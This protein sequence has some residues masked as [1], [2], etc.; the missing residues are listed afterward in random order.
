MLTVVHRAPANLD[1]SKKVLRGQAARLSWAWDGLCFAVPM[2][3]SNN[4]GL[5]DVVTNL[6][7]TVATGPPSWAR[8]DRGNPALGFPPTGYLGWADNPVHD[9]PS[10]A[11]TAYIRVRNNAGTRIEGGILYNPWSAGPPWSTW[12]IQSGPTDSST[13]YGSLSVGT[14]IEYITDFTGSITT[15]QWFSAFLRWRSGEALTMDVLDERGWLLYSVSSSSAVIGALGYNPGR[16]I[17][18]NSTAADSNY[19]GTYSQALVWNRRLTD[20]EL[21]ALVSDPYGWYSPRRET[22]GTSSP[23]PLIAGAGEM[24]SGGGGGGIY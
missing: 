15:T 17:L 11:L 9:R 14:D 4:E 24:K 16:G 8:D 3:E 21:T 7:P 20:T 5:R 6:M 19:V 18:I 2:H 12:G 10:T 23:Y 22:T 1:K 13:L